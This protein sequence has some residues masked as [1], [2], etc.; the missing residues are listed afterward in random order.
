MNS[1]ASDQFSA[2][3][4]STNSEQMENK[5]SELFDKL[6]RNVEFGRGK[7]TL[8]NVAENDASLSSAAKLEELRDSMIALM[9]TD[10]TLLKQ[11]EALRE[12]IE[13]LKTVSMVTAFSL[14]GGSS[15]EDLD[16]CNC[17]ITNLNCESQ[18]ELQ[19]EFPGKRYFSRQNSV[20]RIP[21]PPT[22]LRGKRFSPGELGVAAKMSQRPLSD[23]SFTASSKRQQDAHEKAIA[24]N[25]NPVKITTYA[26]SLTVNH[27]CQSSFDSDVKQCL[28]LTSSGIKMVETPVEFGPVIFPPNDQRTLPIVQKAPI[29]N[30]SI[31]EHPKYATRRLIE[32]RGPELVNN[33]LIHQQYGVRAVRGGFLHHNHFETIRKKVNPWITKSSFAIWRVDPPWL[34]RTKIP[35][36][37]KLGG[38]KRS[39]HHYVSPVRAGRII[40]EYGGYVTI[41]EALRILKN[42]AISLPFP[43]EM[44]TQEDL[45][46]EEKTKKFIEENN[47]NIYTW[48]FMMKWNMQNCSRWLSQYDYIWGG[49]YR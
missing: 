4:L 39:I 7:L 49:K 37:M 14:S 6:R 25:E 36:G 31:G 24:C 8:L 9:D 45:V 20:L 21:I 16:E 47:R 46:E 30:P 40:I 42:V 5:Q 35:Q 13:N 48:E 43:A 3:I 29:F 44:V 11:M 34:P 38:G 18:A 32:I 26:E 17:D 10:A 41:D 33:K 28:V 15:L 22:R 27:D 23:A 19:Q 2:S 1:T 12:A